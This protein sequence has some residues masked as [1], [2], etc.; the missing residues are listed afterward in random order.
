MANSARIR[1]WRSIGCLLG[2]L[3]LSA[4]LGAPKLPATLQPAADARDALA[5]TDGLEALIDRG[6]VSEDDRQ[7]AYNAIRTWREPTAAYAFARASLAGRVAQV[8]RL[9][10]VKLVG[11]MER[12]AR[13][14]IELDRTFRRGAARRMLGT[15]Y[16]LA[17]GS[18]LSHGDS[19]E[20]L[21]LLEEL[22][23]EFP[24]DLQN[25]LR[26]AEGFV[27]LNDPEPAFPALC[28]CWRERE[29]LRPGERR[30]L[31][32]LLDEVGGLQELDCD[33]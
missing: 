9:S 15:L 1:W 25:H 30:L 10:A 17:P 33:S 29:A 27:R 11:E 24:D 19:E 12:Y 4:C 23:E 2:A 21:E 31:D 3:T 18:L 7:A 32:A 22:L 26:V 5:L 6:E 20:G 13:R 16:V 28:R 14:S 8:K